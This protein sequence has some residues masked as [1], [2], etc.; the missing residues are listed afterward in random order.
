MRNPELNMQT[1]SL[2]CRL[3][4]SWACVFVTSAATLGAERP[5]KPNIII[6]MADDM[7]IGDTSAYLGIRLSPKAPPI[8]KTL[9]TPNLE[10]FARSAIVFTDGYAPAS[11]CSATRYSL[12]TGRFAHRL[13]GLRD[14]RKQ[15]P[16]GRVGGCLHQVFERRRRCRSRPR[17]RRR[18]PAGRWGR[19]MEESAQTAKKKVLEIHF[20]QFSPNLSL[21]FLIFFLS[22]EA[23]FARSGRDSR[24]A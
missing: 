24:F 9:R 16:A 2:T 20:S 10:K 5:S 7:G 8:E 23:D 15:P 12:L 11:M 17:T 4:I 1:N 6:M 18:P 14:L 19:P 13:D 3:I 22:I 21:G